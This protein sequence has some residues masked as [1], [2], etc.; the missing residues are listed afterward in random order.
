MLGWHIVGYLQEGHSSSKGRQGDPILFSWDAGLGGMNWMDE[1]VK[2]GVAKQIGHNGGY[3]LVYT[4]RK[5]D[6]VLAIENLTARDFKSSLNFDH[7]WDAL[8]P[9]MLVAVDF[10]DQS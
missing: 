9:D 8:A 4:A 2:S 5:K 6:L 7:K 10:W 3:P 1:L